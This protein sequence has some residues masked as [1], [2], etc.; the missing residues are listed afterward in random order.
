MENL[1]KIKNELDYYIKFCREAIDSLGTSELA[2]ARITSSTPLREPLEKRGLIRPGARDIDVIMAQRQDLIDVKVNHTKRVVEDILTMAQKIGVNV[3]FKEVLHCAA[4]LHDI[5]RFEYAVWNDAY[6]EVGYK[7]QQER[8]IGFGGKFAVFGE[9]LPVENHAKAGEY[10]LKE[11]QIIETLS[12]QPEYFKLIVQ[13][14]SHH[15]DAVLEGATNHFDE[16]LI[17]TPLEDLITRESTFNEAEKSIYVTMTQLLKDIDCIDI[18][19][20]HLTGEF[21]VIRPTVTFNKNVKDRS[22][23]TV[24][25][26]HSLEDFAAYWGFTPA[27]VAEYNGLTLEE[28]EQKD[29]LRLPVYDAETKKLFISP[30]KLVMPADLQEKFFNLERLDLQEINKRFDWNPIV[31]MWW[32]LL[33]FLGNV[34]FSAN[35][36]IIQERNLLDQILALYPEELKPNVIKAFEF[37]KENLLGNRGNDIYTNKVF[38]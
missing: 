3:N 35:I 29:N 32:R 4:L 13:A 33:H 15:Q 34:S 18:L 9:N 20:Q 38:K 28:A 31:G 36:A 5:G 30:E 25:E 22:G 24:V 1:E 14:V 17:N 8:R 7:S 27:Y 11:R 12:K 37:A 26:K 16:R 2:D 10:L 21:P 23:K 19:Y 6:G